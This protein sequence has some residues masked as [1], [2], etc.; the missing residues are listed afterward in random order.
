MSVPVNDHRAE[1]SVAQ[2]D[3]PRKTLEN[4]AGSPLLWIAAS[5]RGFVDTIMHLLK[6]FLYW[7]PEALEELDFFLAGRL[8]EGWWIG[9]KLEQYAPVG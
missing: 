9:L 6:T 1:L 7:I 8:G 2:Q 3:W 4:P 5:I